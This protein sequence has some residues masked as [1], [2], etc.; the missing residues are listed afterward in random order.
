MTNE[1]ELLRT[2]PLRDPTGYLTKSSIISGLIRE[3]ERPWR[4][5]KTLPSSSITEILFLYGYTKRIT[6]MGTKTSQLV[7][8]GAM[9][10]AYITAV[11]RSSW[12]KIHPSTK[13][14]GETDVV[15]HKLRRRS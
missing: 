9:S 14:E 4:F 11:G 12:R 6:Q 13:E 15:L 5:L 7:V 3:H 2:T 10:L 8:H 1:F